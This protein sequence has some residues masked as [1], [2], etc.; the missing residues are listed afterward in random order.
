MKQIQNTEEMAACS[1]MY[2]GVKQKIALRVC[3]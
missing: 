3:N 2:V 1:V